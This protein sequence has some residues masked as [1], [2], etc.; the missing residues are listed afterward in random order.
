MDYALIW[1]AIIAF[2]VLMYVILDG[3]DL[4]VALHF[5][6]FKAE[7]EKDVLMNSVAPVWD[8]N[9]TWLILGGGGLFAVFPL[10]YAI[11]MPA[12]Y[13]PVIAMLLGLVFRGVAFEYRFKTQRGK[14]IWDLSFYLGS[15]TASLMQGI[16]LGGLL[17]G[18][19]VEG[20]AYAGGWFDW[21]TPFSL[22]CGV[23]LTIGYG[24]LG[25]T[26]LIMK[27]SGAIRERAIGFARLNF[28]LLVTCILAVSL[29][30]P[31]TDEA[32]AKRWFSFPASLI[33][34]LSPL[35][36]A[37]VTV[38]FY[39][40]VLRSR[41]WLPYLLTIVLFLGA[42]VGFSITLFPYMVPPAITLWEAAAPDE[43]L[44]FL[45]VG[46]VFL[47]PIILAYTAYAYWVFR[48]KMVIGEGYH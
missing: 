29:Y 33:F 2:A 34:W 43:S 4:G 17:Q 21:L 18:I 16:I 48:G 15:L 8:G 31:L 25:S 47:L 24:A 19:E 3:F 32:V 7:E 37:A 10:A 30:L 23:A 9:E 14:P 39:W 12:F 45:L 46:A 26:W 44:R 40:A 22:F 5:P 41:D 35:L 36:I 38:L 1:A 28:G 27:T 20:R 6:F 11:V 42:F 13:M